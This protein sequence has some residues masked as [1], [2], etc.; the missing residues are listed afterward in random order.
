MGVTHGLNK[1]AAKMDRIIR[2]QLKSPQVK[3][4]QPSSR[5]STS[6]IGPGVSSMLLICSEVPEGA[7]SCNL[8]IF[9]VTE[10]M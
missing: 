4:N 2:K 3:E 8:K 7:S 10:R 5:Y 1:M 6:K 9:L